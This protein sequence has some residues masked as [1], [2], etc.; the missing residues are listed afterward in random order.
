MYILFCECG[1]DMQ[2]KMMY[3]QLVIQG[4]SDVLISQRVVPA[5]VTLAN[6]PDM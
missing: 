2:M 5:L 3:V 1:T 4:V 6:D